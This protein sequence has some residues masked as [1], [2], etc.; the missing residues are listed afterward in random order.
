M[1][2]ENRSEESM[3]PADD[4]GGREAR[5]PAT[6]AAARARRVRLERARQGLDSGTTSA[7]T[8]AQV[9]AITPAVGTA[10]AMDGGVELATGEGDPG[11]LLGTGAVREAIKALSRTGMNANMATTGQAAGDAAGYTTPAQTQIAV[12][13]TQVVPQVA[14]SRQQT[15]ADVAAELI[16]L[17]NQQQGENAAEAAPQR[18]SPR[19][20]GRSCVGCGTVVTTKWTPLGAGFVCDRCITSRVSHSHRI[21]YWAERL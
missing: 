13:N 19:A 6:T 5:S 9:P 17:Q 3:L 2:K 18:R 16:A 21:D 1:S 11:N 12:G 14:P 10:D 8:A 4:T 15:E 7:A 20:S